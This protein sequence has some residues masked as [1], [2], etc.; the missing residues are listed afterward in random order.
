MKKLLLIINPRAG[1]LKANKYLADIIGVFNRGGYDVTAYV[2]KARGDAARVAR[3]RAKEVDLIVCC[4]GDGTFNETVSGLL[5]SGERTPIGYIPC[6][7]TNDFAH[8]LGLPS[9]VVEAAIRIVRGKPRALDIGRFGERYFSYVASFGAF[10]KTSYATSQTVKNALGHMAYLLGGVKELN[11]LQSEH[12][13]M[14]LDGKVLDGYYLFGA[15]CN[16]TSIGG[17]LKLDPSRVDL[18]DGKF[19]ILLVR[20]PKDFDEVKECVRAVMDHSFNCRMMT[21]LSARDIT[22]CANPD[23]NWTLD[24]E[25]AQGVKKLRVENLHRAIRLVR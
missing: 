4:G 22:V 16:S 7:S 25:M 11:H 19:E 10:T 17:V 20:A 6:G 14:K 23:M 5:E 3:E 18:S 2:T 21:F 1:T 12:V 9:D 24:G 8:T 13:R 15:I